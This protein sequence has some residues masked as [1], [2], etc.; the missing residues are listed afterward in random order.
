MN[1][2][3]TVDSKLLF[4]SCKVL[5]HEA[6]HLFGIRHC[7][8]YECLMCGCNHLQE[9]DKRPMYLCPVDL[10]K[11]QSSL[12]FDVAVRYK[13]LLE[14]VRDFGWEELTSFFHTRLTELVG[15]YTKCSPVEAERKTTANKSATTRTRPN[16]KSAATTATKNKNKKVQSLSP[17]PAV[18]ERKKQRNRS[19]A[20]K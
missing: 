17:S 12:K 6:G 10:R 13:H 14:V 2:E 7:T 1:K 19:R 15:D 9:F 3:G 20:S 18:A 4:R 8:F 16:E 5:T 11:L